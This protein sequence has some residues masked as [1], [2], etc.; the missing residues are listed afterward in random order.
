M[1]T[2]TR[3]RLFQ[4]T[5]AFGA[6]T[7]IA[8][9]LPFEG[10]ADGS[11]VSV[12]LDVQQ[13]AGRP[14]YNG[15]IPGPTIMIDPGDV[16]D[17]RLINSLPAI[18]PGDDCGDHNSIHGVH[19]TNLHTHGLH[20]SPYKDSSGSFDA[21]N[22]F[23]KVTPKDQVVDCL[24]DDFRD[25]E[26]DYRFELPADHP[27]GTHW[28]HAHKHGSTNFQVGS[29]LAGPLIVR[30]PPGSMPSYIENAEE[31]VFMLMDRGVVL[32]DPNGGGVRN[33]TITM[34]PGEV[35]R[36]R[37]INARV[38][39]NAF[40]HLGANAPE[41]DMV[42]IAYDGLTL[43]APFVVD[44]TNRDEPWE[45]PAALAPGNRTDIMVHV[46]N[47]APEGEISI[48]A[49][50]APDEFLHGTG[51]AA[52]AAPSQ[53]RIMV[54]GDAVDHEWD[55][56]APLPGPGI[57]PISTVVD[58]TQ[59]VSFNT[60]SLGRFAID[61]KLYENTV[62]RTMAL[63]ST[64]EWT[65]LNETPAT[66]PFH[67]HVNPFLVT[68]IDGRE[69]AENDPLRR[70]QDTIALPGS[71]IS[72]PGSVKFKTRFSDFAGAFVIHCHILQHEDLGMMQKVEVR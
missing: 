62:Q 47:T 21:D 15:K 18:I 9:L 36:W 40:V 57:S 33:P 25:Y 68:H 35:Q 30:D 37:I 24:N 53:I 45:N 23:L 60:D 72:G 71:S 29:G 46:P 44:P 34:R 66:H 13:V 38:S 64:E 54:E 55:P 39:A 67:I 27:P 5:G 65:V 19:T 41:V 28:Y 31:K 56:D 43:T 22:V 10:L 12:T 70:W 7:A 1:S 20:V 51:I 63:G 58:R 48:N 32:V 26:N 8:G 49:L 17:V 50:Q 3:R 61:G 11:T 4:K 14:T 42:Q 59:T 52:L 69:L 6:S 16:L 2:F